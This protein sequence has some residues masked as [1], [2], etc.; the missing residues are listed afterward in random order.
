MLSGAMSARDAA[1]ATKDATLGG[2]KPG[3]RPGTTGSVPTAL[4]RA[5]RVRRF[6][7]DCADELVWGAGWEPGGEYT[8]QLVIKNV[9]T[10]V[11]KIKYQLPVSKY[12]SMAFPETIN[13]TA[14]LSKTLQVRRQSPTA[15]VLAYHQPCHAASAASAASAL[16]ETC[17]VPAGLCLMPHSRSVE[18]SC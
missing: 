4:T 16:H 8:K 13:L 7:V 9:G 5:Q 15:S 6:G 3:S 10:K 12:F 14:G 17:P 1:G 18:A 2:S 11:M